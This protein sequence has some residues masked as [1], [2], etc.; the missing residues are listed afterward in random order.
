MNSLWGKY[1]GIV[2]LVSLVVL[3]P[4]A[5]YMLSWHRT[6][7]LFFQCRNV[8]SRIQSFGANQDKNGGF[9]GKRDAKWEDIGLDI[10]G[11][12]LISSGLVLD[13]VEK[14]CAISSFTPSFIEDEGVRVHLGELV[15]TG[16]FADAIRTM[17]NIESLDGVSLLSA[18]FQSG[19]KRRSGD[20]Y[21]NAKDNS[22]ADVI[23]VTLLMQQIMMSEEPEKKEK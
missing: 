11:T 13:A 17:W 3:L 6:A 10:A 21:Y 7:Q 2:C 20:A 18:Q 12:D 16:G 4:V 22:M 9:D 15:F 23:T 1:K 8:E 14:G 5:V 19:T